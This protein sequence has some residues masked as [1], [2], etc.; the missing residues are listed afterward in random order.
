MRDS[1]GIARENHI[2]QI[3]L[4]SPRKVRRGFSE[5][6]R[7]THPQVLLTFPGEKKKIV[8]QAQRDMK[9]SVEEVIIQ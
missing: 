3:S 9:E 1:R 8:N 7:P 5:L 4:Q 2:R 6:L